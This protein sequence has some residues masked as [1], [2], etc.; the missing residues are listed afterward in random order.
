MSSGQFE[1]VFDF[2]ELPALN[3]FS[4]EESKHVTARSAIM[5]SCL[6][7]GEASSAEVM[8]WVMRRIKKKQEAKEMSQQ[9]VT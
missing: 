1:A 9:V 6:M 7:E 2:L 4:T 8:N 5:A 3:R